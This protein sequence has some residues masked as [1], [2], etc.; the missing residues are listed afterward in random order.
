MQTVLIAQRRRR[1]LNAIIADAKARVARRRARPPPKPKAKAARKFKAQP[2]ARSPLVPGY[3][4]LVV[5][6]NI[7]L[8]ARPLFVD[9][10][11]SQRW[12]IIVPLCGASGE[13][14]LALTSQ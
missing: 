11:D 7:P 2:V 3:T 14:E 8:M 6:T 10:V 4:V 13:V 12:F 5:D 9:L 1:E